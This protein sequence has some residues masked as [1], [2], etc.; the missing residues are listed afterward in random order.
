[1]TIQALM[2]RENLAFEAK[3][4]PLNQ[5]NRPLQPT[6]GYSHV[7]SAGSKA[8]RSAKDREADQ[9]S[10]NIAHDDGRAPRRA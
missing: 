10:E 3:N 5:E 2:N 9:D 7:S 8:T 6:V 4:R 1:M